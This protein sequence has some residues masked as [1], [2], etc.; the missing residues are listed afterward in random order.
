MRVLSCGQG[1]YEGAATQQKVPR[2]RHDVGRQP[3]MHRAAEHLVEQNPPA[4]KYY[5]IFCLTC[6]NLCILVATPCLEELEAR[7]LL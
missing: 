4:C 7:V 5:Q 3:R 2:A 1:N 6:G